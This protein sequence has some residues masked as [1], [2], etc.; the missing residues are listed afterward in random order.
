[1]IRSFAW[2]LS[3]GMLA[4]CQNVSQPTFDTFAGR[5]LPPPALRAQPTPAAPYY[6]PGA[7]PPAQ[8]S[9]S[10]SPPA[11][12]PSASWQA[13]PPANTASSWPANRSAPAVT[14]PATSP[15]ATAPA[16]AQPG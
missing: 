16:V 15:T 1:M 14:P 10:A 13:T 2:L 3:A 5:T 12:Q 7:V 8:P 4:G 11:G 9:W 6:A